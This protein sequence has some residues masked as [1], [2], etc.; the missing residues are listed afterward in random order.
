MIHKIPNP[1]RYKIQLWEIPIE[2]KHPSGTEEIKKIFGK[3][4]VVPK[5]LEQLF[6]ETIVY[7]PELKDTHIIVVENKFYG[8]QHTLRS[9]PPL[10]SLL[11]NKKDRV[12]P[13]VIN[14]NK[15]TPIPF[16]SLSKE[17]QKGI[18]AHEMAHVLDYT[19]R[20][21]TELLG[22]SYMFC[23]SKDFIQKLEK[24]TDNVAISRGFEDDILKFR[25]HAK[26][27][28][29]SSYKYYEK[30]IYE[31]NKINTLK[32]LRFS[33]L[34]TINTALGFLVAFEEMIVLIYIK[35]IHKQS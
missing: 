2:N 16:Y 26:E 25:N 11:N 15:N 3:N 4:K 35:K 18:L 6:Y 28:S 29:T 23:F 10:L 1:F 33:V 24:N 5:H 19:K 30:I 14:T 34:H 9:Y 22:L 12:I 31:V 17:E 8:I 13:I 7:Y 20:S 21:A 32:T 27:N